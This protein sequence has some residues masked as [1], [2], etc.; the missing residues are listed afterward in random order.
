MAPALTDSP[1][2]NPHPCPPILKSE[3][4]LLR[5][6]WTNTEYHSFSKE[7]Q[8]G[9]DFIDG[10]HFAPHFPLIHHCLGEAF[11]MV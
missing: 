3:I 4:N 7:L 11:E 1:N 2:P 9:E 8:H 5:I 10:T 6:T